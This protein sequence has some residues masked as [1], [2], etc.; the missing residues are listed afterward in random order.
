MRVI[1]T[2]DGDLLVPQNPSLGIA[3]Q[4]EEITR[5][6]KAIG[7]LLLSP[8]EVVITHGNAPQVGFMLLRAELASHI[9]HS[10]P[11]DVCGADTQGA[12]GYLLQQA[13]RNWLEVN[14]VSKEVVS[15]VTQVLVDPIQPTPNRPERGIGPFFDQEKAQT[16]RNTRGWDFVLIPGRGYRRAVPSLTPKA[17][18]EIN[19]IRRLLDPVTIVVCAGG[20]GVPVVRDPNGELVGV[21]AVVDKADTT[22]LLARELQ[23]EGILFVS[24][25]DRL[26]QLPGIKSSGELTVLSLSELQTILNRASEFDDDSYHKLI[27][28]RVFLEGGGKWV[29]FAPPEGVR[30]SLEFT[31]GILLQNDRVEKSTQ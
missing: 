1:V 24:V 5:V 26:K 25:W 11:L 13:V 9:V 16:Y 17:L 4:R 14:H 27:A 29:H 30:A 8:N 21:E 7:G 31:Q 22:G 12:T 3:G 10:L 20:G 6:V 2:I 18:P 28:A 23:A 19:L 15:L